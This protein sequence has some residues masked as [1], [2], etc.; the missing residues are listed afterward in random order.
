MFEISKQSEK[1]SVI[2]QVGKENL[3]RQLHSFTNRHTTGRDTV[4]GPTNSK[5]KVATTSPLP[6]SADRRTERRTNRNVT[7]GW[8]D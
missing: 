6:E 2:K 3:G 8:M 4:K 7:D 5:L 1:Q